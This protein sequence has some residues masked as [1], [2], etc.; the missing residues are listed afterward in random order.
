MIIEAQVT[1]NRSRAAI[2]AVI[3]NIENAAQTI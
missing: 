1:I 2:W 3:T